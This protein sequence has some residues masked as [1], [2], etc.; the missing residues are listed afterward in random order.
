MYMET[1]KK[2]SETEVIPMDVSDCCGAR[3]KGGADSI[4]CVACYNPC[5][6]VPD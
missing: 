4:Y 2:T 6:I 1:I 3:A 5:G